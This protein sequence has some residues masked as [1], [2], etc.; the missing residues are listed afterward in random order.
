MPSPPF[1]NNTHKASMSLITNMKV[2]RL[3]LVIASICIAS[4]SVH[5]ST[6]HHAETDAI[7]LMP[8]GAALPVHKLAAS[9]DAI[10]PSRRSRASRLHKRQN[11]DDK[12][13]ILMLLILAGVLTLPKLVLAIQR[14]DGRAMSALLAFIIFIIYSWFGPGSGGHRYRLESAPSRPMHSFVL[15]PPVYA[16]SEHH[17]AHR[18]ARPHP[19]GHGSNPGIHHGDSLTQG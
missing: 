19:P 6:W 10:Q 5:A 13:F 17:G 3:I 15:P 11:R 1:T 4:S 12:I 7:A 14:I 16:V 2:T 8:L 18:N 9:G